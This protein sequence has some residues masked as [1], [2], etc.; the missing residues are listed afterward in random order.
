MDL[1]KDFVT[2][3]PSDGGGNASVN[4]TADV[5]A[6]YQPRET[7]IS[8][9]PANGTAKEVTIS[10]NGIPYIVQV[11]VSVSST[12]I[13]DNHI[14]PE[15]FERT[16]AAS[17]IPRPRVK[18]TITKG[19]LND[20]EHII[21]V[22]FG[23]LNSFWSP[24]DDDELIINFAYYQGPGIELEST[25]TV[26][27]YDSDD[28]LDWSNYICDFVVGGS[29]GLTPHSDAKYLKILVGLGRGDIGIDDDKI[30]MEYWL[31]LN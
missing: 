3:S 18:G 4:I 5:N 23:C 30:L 8:V 26:F 29:M 6:T 13:G 15:F 14:I 11:G 12:S 25:Q 20:D 2:V 16:N 9:I 7:S 31:L 24:S 10:Q 1:K 21:T 28:G 27:T 17:G 19:I 22:L